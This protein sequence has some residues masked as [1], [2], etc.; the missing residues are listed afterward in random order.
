MYIT[1]F[2]TWRISTVR[3]LPPRLAGGI[4]G[5]TSPHFDV[6]QIALITQMPTVIAASVLRSPHQTAP[7]CA[8]GRQ[9]GSG[10]KEFKRAAANQFKELNLFLDR[11]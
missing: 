6:G 3:L 10:V 11:H 8:K 4:S 2:V 1:P 9:N 5:P 7:K